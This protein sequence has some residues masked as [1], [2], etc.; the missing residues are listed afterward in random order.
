MKIIY[1]LLLLVHITV[2]R[3]NVRK[4]FNRRQ[5]RKILTTLVLMTMVAVDDGH[6]N[7]FTVVNHVAHVAQPN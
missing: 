2:V 7:F 3:F 5:R 6:G 1:L 4:F